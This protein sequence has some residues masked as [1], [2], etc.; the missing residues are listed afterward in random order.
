MQQTC[1]WRKKKPDSAAG[2]DVGSPHPQ[3]SARIIFSNH[4]ADHR[5]LA[6]AF[7]YQRRDLFREFWQDL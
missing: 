2:L 1:S 7:A 4:G 3:T 5:A 6:R